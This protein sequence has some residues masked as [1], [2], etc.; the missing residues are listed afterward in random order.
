MRRAERTSD[1]VQS[2]SQGEAIESHTVRGR[3]Y[4]PLYVVTMH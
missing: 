1:R 3:M 2:R 4:A